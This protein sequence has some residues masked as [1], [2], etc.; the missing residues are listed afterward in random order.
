MSDELL[1]LWKYE[2]RA[3][4]KYLTNKGKN[5]TE[6]NEEL[7]STYPDTA[8]SYGTIRRWIGLLQKGRKYEESDSGYSSFIEED[9][10]DVKDLMFEDRRIVT[11]IADM[12]NISKEYVG[13][14]FHNV[15][16][17][18]AKMLTRLHSSAKCY[19]CRYNCFL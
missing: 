5:V 18:S 17:V 10:E 1:I 9:I 7:L 14:I 12:F 19:P 13:E 6:I 8:P 2:F 15:H 3:V 16:K 4:I 11:Q